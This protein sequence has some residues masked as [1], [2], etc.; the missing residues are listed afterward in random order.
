MTTNLK[1]SPSLKSTSI[2]NSETFINQLKKSY[3]ADQQ[4]KYLSLHAEIDLL[5]H[6]VQS[7]KK[8]IN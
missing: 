7:V 3:Q 1:S 6:Q 4:V 2:L 8:E 5:L